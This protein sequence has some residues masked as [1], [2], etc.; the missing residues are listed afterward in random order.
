MPG[1]RGK[2]SSTA[3]A[4]AAGCYPVGTVVEA[5]VAEV[6]GFGVVFNLPNAPL[7]GFVPWPK[8]DP[9]GGLVGPGSDDAPRVG[10]R[11]E[12]VILAH[13]LDRHQLAA[14]CRLADFPDR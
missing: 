8:I 10:E 14:S 6:W 2:P 7:T 12:V 9:S 3:I 13:Q 4:H 11:R 5:T 1:S